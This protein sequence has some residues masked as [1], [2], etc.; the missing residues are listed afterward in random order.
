MVSRELRMPMSSVHLRGTSTET[1][2]NTNA[3]GGSV[4]ADLNG[5]AVKVKPPKVASFT[6]PLG[7]DPWLGIRREE[8]FISQVSSVQGRVGTQTQQGRSTQQFCARCSTGHQSSYFH[9]KPPLSSPFCVQ[10]DSYLLPGLRAM[11]SLHPSSL[12]FAL[13]S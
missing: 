10:S 7:S 3:S 13:A 4:V 9:P 5:L 12:C 1:V 6:S 2:P 8:S 11:P